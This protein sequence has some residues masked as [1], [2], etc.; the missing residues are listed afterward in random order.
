MT[1]KHILPYINYTVFNQL[2]TLNP[3]TNKYTANII[4]ISVITY[5]LLNNTK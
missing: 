2:K 3:I 5:N 1:S 4:H